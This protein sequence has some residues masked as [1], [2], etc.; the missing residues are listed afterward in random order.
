MTA[1]RRLEGRVAL[2]TG[3]ASGN[4]RAIALRYAAEGAA[5][6]CADLVPNPIAGGWEDSTTTHD[7]IN[8]Q[9]GRATFVEC[10]VT[11]G[12]QVAATVANLLL[13][14]RAESI[15][16]TTIRMDGGHDAVLAAETRTE[17]MD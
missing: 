11:D 13:G 6:V 12:G 7:L 5:V 14:T 2:I 1:E 10:D 9:G 17:E 3:A 8:E 16:G 4:G 15:N